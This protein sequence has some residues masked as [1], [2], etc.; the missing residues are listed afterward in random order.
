MFKVKAFFNNFFIINKDVVV[1]AM[2]TKE[3]SANQL[4]DLLNSREATLMRII[5][6]DAF[7]ESIAYDCHDKNH[8]NRW[9]P[10]CAN[11]RDGIEE[12]RKAI[13]K[14]AGLIK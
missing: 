13:M 1:L 2:C 7:S 4:C 12:Y 3:E 10:T 6:D 5:S 9:C 11:R 8:D 14:K